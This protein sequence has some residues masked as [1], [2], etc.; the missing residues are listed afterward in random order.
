MLKFW[1]AHNDPCTKHR[2]GRRDVYI[3]LQGFFPKR[4]DHE[5]G[6]TLFFT[7]P[8]NCIEL[9]RWPTKEWEESLQLL[10]IAKGHCFEVAMVG[11]PNLI[12]M[13]V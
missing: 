7:G 10:R 5:C 4:E 9:G 6:C 12:T 2:S 13:G 8:F 3:L 11:I 1:L